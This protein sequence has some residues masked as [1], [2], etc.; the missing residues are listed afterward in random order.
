MEIEY[1]KEF[2]SPEGHW[3]YI[4]DIYRPTIEDLTSTYK[5]SSM[6]EI[7][8]NIGYSTYMFL[9][10]DTTQK[11]EITSVDIA[12]H[13]CTVD[14]AAK[15]K[16]LHPSRFSFIACSSRLAFKQFS[17]KE[18]DLVFID[19]DHTAI[20]CVSDIQIA[21]DLQAPY[22]LFDDYH[23]SDTPVNSIRNI[24]EAHPDLTL[25]KL[26]PAGD[27]DFRI[28]LYSTPFKV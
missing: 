9:E 24:A 1:L 22:V 18:Y 11:L 13:P 23:V 20:G 10:G 4:P 27:M 15:M 28:A 3:M 21:L 2:T 17:D 19:G 12:K 8:F 25:E 14:A 5:I 16:E 26:Y 7:G 6:L